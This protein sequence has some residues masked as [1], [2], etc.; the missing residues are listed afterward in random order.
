MTKGGDYYGN[1]LG[2]H[3][4]QKDFEIVYST[5]FTLTVD[6]ISLFR[7]LNGIAKISETTIGMTMKFLPEVGTYKEAQIKRKLT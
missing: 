2:K 6:G 5:I 7:Q 3:I 1:F 4:V